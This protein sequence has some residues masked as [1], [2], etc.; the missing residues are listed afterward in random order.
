MVLQRS[1]Y[2]T[3][4]PQSF[5]LSYIPD[6]REIVIDYELPNKDIMPTVLEY[7]YVKTKDEI[8]ENPENS[9]DSSTC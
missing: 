7:K 8:S 5:R 6:S 3:E 2:P 9:R 4:F 1:E